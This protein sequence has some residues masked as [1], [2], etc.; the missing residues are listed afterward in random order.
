MSS[1][2]SF[3][4]SAASRKPEQS[5]QIDRARMRSQA[6]NATLLCDQRLVLFSGI[7]KIDSK[8]IWIVR[9]CRITMPT[10]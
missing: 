7:V 4:E 3:P 2:F 10:K 9:A 6:R 1:Y 8:H 5:R